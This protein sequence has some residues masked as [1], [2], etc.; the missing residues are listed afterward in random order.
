VLDLQEAALRIDGLGSGPESAELDMV[1]VA[2]LVPTG[3]HIDL[4]VATSS[5][6]MSEY[7]GASLV[8]LSVSVDVP[9]L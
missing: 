2:Y 1:A 3:H 5:N 7:R 8:N 9:V 6:A 4:Q